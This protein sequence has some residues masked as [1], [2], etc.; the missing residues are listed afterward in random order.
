MIPHL[1][2]ARA[3]SSRLAD[4]QHVMTR[5]IDV[6][7]SEIF[8]TLVKKLASSR[9]T[10]YNNTPVQVWQSPI[11]ACPPALLT[12]VGI[13]FA[14]RPENRSP[15]PLKGTVGEVRTAFLPP[16]APFPRQ[17]GKGYVTSSLLAPALRAGSFRQ[18][19]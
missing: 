16:I 8:E 7:Y 18:R 9:A 19:E 17:G 13:L 1:P 15:A 3:F 14:V 12:A 11:I 4:A 10:C 5:P 6:G 2:S